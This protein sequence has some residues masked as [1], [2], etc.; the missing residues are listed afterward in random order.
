MFPSQDMGSFSIF[1][2]VGTQPVGPK[3][4]VMGHFDDVI[5]SDR[6]LAEAPLIRYPLVIAD[7][8]LL[9]MVIEIVDLPIKNRYFP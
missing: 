4:G 2:H 9:K 3:V 6:R 8:K 7:K 5:E 1:R